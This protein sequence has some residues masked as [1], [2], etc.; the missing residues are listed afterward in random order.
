LRQLENDWLEL[1][2]EAS[3]FARY[4][5]NFAA[6]MHLLD[7][8]EQIWFCRIYDGAGRTL[9]IIP[10]IN[11]KESV[12]PFGQL[13]ALAL[14]W[15]NQLAIFDFPM[16]RA[17]NALEVGKAMLMAC[18]NLP[19]KWQVI[20]WPRVMADSNAAKV[21]LALGQQW[22]D[23]T[24]AAPSSTFYTAS[25][26]DP[27][28]GL[29]IFVVK[30]SKLRSK[31]AYTTRRLSAQGPIQMRMAREQDDIQGYFE[32]FLR[33][34]SSGWKGAHGSGTAIALVPSAK[35]FFS[36]LLVQ[37]N[38]YFETDIALMF[39]AEKAV[40]GQFLIRV[41]RWEHQYKIA[42]DEAYSKLSPGQ[43][44]HQMVIE[45]AKVSD[46]IDR[47]SLVTGQT[48]HKEWAPIP[49]PTL[50]IY[51]FRNIWRTVVVRVGRQV[52]ARARQVRARLSAMRAKDAGSPDQ[53]QSKQDEDQPA[54]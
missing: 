15:S 4:E 36:S 35:A 16:A 29:E 30:S 33:L 34:E 24:P 20:S 1:T 3:L 21:A 41:A 23:I 39:C 28:K 22:T 9:A 5:W 10:A 54:S 2:P 53:K 11:G 49:E 52:L 27:A 18:K 42:Y 46:G 31:L 48:W 19:F 40:A 12:K 6:A 45:Q 47:V 51:I 13:P 25:A 8:G 14:G 37:S 32:E 44:L 17:A 7:E 38:P 50:Q 26:P 43:I